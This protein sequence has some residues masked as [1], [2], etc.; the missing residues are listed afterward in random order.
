MRKP[1]CKTSDTI[2]LIE[3]A[4]ASTLSRLCGGDHNQEAAIAN[5]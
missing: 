3:I 5:T 4:N 1:L 2:Q